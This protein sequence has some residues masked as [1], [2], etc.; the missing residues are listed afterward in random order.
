MVKT[1]A[2]LNIVVNFNTCY[3]FYAASC[4]VLMSYWPDDGCDKPKHFAIN[5]DIVIYDI[6]VFYD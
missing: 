1:I 5:L 3:I 4:F 2:Y 6:V